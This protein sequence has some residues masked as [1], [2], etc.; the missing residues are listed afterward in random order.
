MTIV[1]RLYE[2]STILK[3]PSTR[4]RTGDFNSVEKTIFRSCNGYRGWTCRR[5]ELFRQSAELLEFVQ[6]LLLF[7]LILSV[8]CCRLIR[9]KK[10]CGIFCCR[11]T[12]FT[13]IACLD[14][15]LVSHRRVSAEESQ[16][17]PKVWNSRNSPPA[18]C[19]EVWYR[20]EFAGK[21]AGYELIST[22]PFHQAA[23][24]A[25]LKK[26]DPEAGR[27][28]RRVRDTHLRLQ[29]F[30]RE[31]S[32]SARLETVETVDGLLSSWKLV[33]TAAD[34]TTI[35]RSGNWDSD[36]SA[37]V[38]RDHSGDA[39]TTSLISGTE[40]PRSPLIST[41]A[42]AFVSENV[43]V[44]STPVLFPE[45]SAIFDI[46]LSH[47]GGS[48][49]QLAD[50][51]RVSGA[52]FGWQPDGRADL[53]SEAFVEKGGTV[54]QIQ[55]PLLGKILSLN[56]TTAEAALGYSD[57][58]ALDVHV[59]TFLPVTGSIPESSSL[60]FVRLKIVRKSGELLTLP[61]SDFQKV[62]S[63]GPESLIIRLIRPVWS[64]A[65]SP[66]RL[67]TASQAEGLYLSANRWIESRNPEIGRT[68][69]IAVGTASQGEEKCRRLT[70]YVWKQMRFSP[71]ST[72]LVPATT[73]ARTLEGDCTEHAVL[74]CSLL[75][76]QAI[77]AR[78]S[79]GF[80]YFSDGPAFAPH[81]WVEAFVNGL[82]MPLDSTRGLSE[83]GLGYLKVSD[84][85][86][87]NDA[88]MGV[89]VFAP[90]LEFAGKVSIEV[91]TE[92]DR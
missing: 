66:S 42:A 67:K 53:K 49:L 47:L 5:N 68:A 92:G 55:Q 28:L 73:I 88:T 74:L 51:R 40:Q 27:L 12:L 69:L 70:Q 77:P 30:S 75:R 58:A 89:S 11:R 63:V 39:E 7:S 6:A 82:W 80:I 71:F 56:R 45:T 24:E 60:N 38:V 84:S 86:L 2:Q 31:I 21:P 4:Y 25:V 54:L 79:V 59:Q 61:K 1:P 91:L 76:S 15:A 90:L 22:A 44:I 65:A 34:G 37:M 33:R 35:E 83:T 72:Q 87:D 19:Q 13:V 78:V 48:S 32:L 17:S 10:C 85:A 8:S 57:L 26:S 62:E 9:M 3:E 52:R 23:T 81:M 46:R 18:V 64:P 36:Q 43:G 50:G 20:I 16:V 14:L 41:W 29:R